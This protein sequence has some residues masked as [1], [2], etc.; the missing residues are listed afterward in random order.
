MVSVDGVEKDIPAVGDVELQPGEMLGHRLSGGGG[1]GDPSERDPELVRADVLARFISFE[2][3]RDV[4]RVAFTS[5]LL[6]DQLEI[7]VESTERLRTET[8]VQTPSDCETQ[9]DE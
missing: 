7:D 2:R 5:N 9:N 4:Y 1:Y 3:A 8:S 6:T